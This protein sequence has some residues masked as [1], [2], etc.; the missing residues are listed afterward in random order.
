M[1]PR[2]ASALAGSIDFNV[3]SLFADTQ[4]APD[5]VAGQPEEGV[6]VAPELGSRFGRWFQ[7]ESSPSGPAALPQAEQAPQQPQAPPF[8]APEP[9]QAANQFFQQQ[10]PPS[11]S[12]AAQIQVPPPPPSHPPPLPTSRKIAPLLPTVCTMEDW[13]RTALEGWFGVVFTS[14]II[15]VEKLQFRADILYVSSAG[16][17]GIWVFF[18]V[19]AC[20]SNLGEIYVWGK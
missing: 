19:R 4:N 18:H 9:Q 20:N 11:A 1:P 6:D 5:A 14:V 7:L 16:G 3:D 10:Q 2:P 8:Q 12:E 13:S 15:T 17:L